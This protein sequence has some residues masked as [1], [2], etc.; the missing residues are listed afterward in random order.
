M[1]GCMLNK[2]EPKIPEAHTLEFMLI[3]PLADGEYVVK[4]HYDGIVYLLTKEG[5]PLTPVILPKEHGMRISSLK[6]LKA[7]NGVAYFDGFL[8]VRPAKK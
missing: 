5:E 2:P 1:T 6:V 4:Y 3:T 8:L 7:L